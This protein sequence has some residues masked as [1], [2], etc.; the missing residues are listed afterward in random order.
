MKPI[1]LLSILG[2]D[3]KIKDLAAGVASRDA[4]SQRSRDLNRTRDAK[5]YFKAMAR[6]KRCC[7][8]ET[9]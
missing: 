7:E 4:G 1:T 5:D 9:R 2:R 3:F 8:G 6:R